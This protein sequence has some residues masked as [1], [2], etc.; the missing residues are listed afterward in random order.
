MGLENEGKRPTFAYMYHLANLKLVL[1]VCS[2]YLDKKI[3]HLKKH[4]EMF[5]Y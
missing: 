4:L 3:K 2:F 1:C 5:V